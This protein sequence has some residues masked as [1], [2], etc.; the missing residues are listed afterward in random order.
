MGCFRLWHTL[1][2]D[3]FYK[4]HVL[5]FESLTHCAEFSEIN[6][7]EFCCLNLWSPVVWPWADL[8]VT[9]L[10]G[11]TSLGGIG[12]FKALPSW[13]LQP[14]PL[15]QDLVGA[16]SSSSCML[17]Q[18]PAMMNSALCTHQPKS[19][20]FCKLLLSSCFLTDATRVIYLPGE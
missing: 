7:L 14:C 20:S 3:A 11:G 5:V 6:P 4:T 16:L 15:L 17:Y 9:L 13:L 10:G 2:V 8:A 19:T 18:L 12:G 1:G